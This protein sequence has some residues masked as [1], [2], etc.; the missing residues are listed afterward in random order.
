MGIKKTGI[1]LNGFLAEVLKERKARSGL[2]FVQLSALTGISERQLK[3]LMADERPIDTAEM[4]AV[5][6]AL[7]VTQFEVVF[8]AVKRMAAGTEKHDGI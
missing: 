3:R 4:E 7:G 5:S 2:T 6:R 8:E 1:P